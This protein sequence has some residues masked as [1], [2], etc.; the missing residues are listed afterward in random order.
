MKRQG[1]TAPLVTYSGFEDDFITANASVLEGSIE[2][3]RVL[4][5]I[6]TSA[7]GLDLFHT[8][9]KKTSANVKFTT[10]QGWGAAD[11]MFQGLKKA[12]ENFDQTKLIA[13]TNSLRWDADGM[14]APIDV[15]RQHVGQSPN[16]AF[17]H[18]D[19]PH[20][21]VYLQVKSGKLTFMKP[22][23]KD[24]PF[25]CWP[26]AHDFNYTEPTAESFG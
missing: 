23:T 10:R 26:Q 12:G 11:E 8:W 17:T 21:F 13:G 1:L 5:D 22:E 16:D 14:F 3:L 2:G 4:P 24:K 18:G 7:P 6:A 15:G 20:C 19:N 9:T 25:A